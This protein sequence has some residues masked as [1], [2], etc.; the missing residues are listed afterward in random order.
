L[1]T[2]K[3]STDV[4]WILIH[5]IESRKLR[6]YGHLVKMAEERKPRQILEA[7]IEGKSALREVWKQFCVLSAVAKF[8]EAAFSQDQ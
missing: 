2:T 8:V 6:W 7:R 5:G 3:H 1:Y 4:I